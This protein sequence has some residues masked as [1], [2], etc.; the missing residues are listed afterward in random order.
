MTRTTPI[1]A[2]A[3]AGLLLVFA[4]GPATASVD[5][6]EQKFLRG[7][8]ESARVELAKVKGKDRARARALMA[9]ID[10]H[11]GAYEKAEKLAKKLTGKKSAK[12]S[13]AGRLLL[14]EIH[15]LRGRFKDA[16]RELEPM[17]VRDPTNLRARWL[18]ALTYRDLGQKKRAEGLFD[19]FFTDFN[20]GKIDENSGEAIFYVAE[21][22]RYLASYEDA[23]NSYQ[24][25]VQL[26]PKFLEA[27]IQY[28]LFGLEKYAIS[29]A[30]EAFENVLGVDPNHPDAHVGMAQVKLD[31]SYD[32][33]AAYHHLKEALKH[34]PRHV[35]ALL[36]RASLEIDQNKWDAA[37][38]TLGEVF[39]VNADNFR[40]R[41]LLATVHWLR[42][43]TRAY[44]SERKR[45]FA[46]NPG[47][48]EFFHIIARS[49][50]REHR[51]KEAVEL[52]KQ[53]VKVDPEYYAAMGEI[54]SGYLRL[55]MEAEGLDWL[56]K[57]WKGDQYN[58]RTYNV[59]NLFEDELP[60]QYTFVSSKNFKFRY[61]NGEKELLH[62]YVAP[63]L[64]RAFADMVKR[65]GFKPKTPIII[66][67]YS[68][69]Q[70][71][72]VRTVGLPNLGALGVCFGQVITTMS[73]SVG[74]INWAMVGWH[75]L[76]HVFAIQLSNSRV[77]RWFTEGLSEYETLIVRPEWRREHDA[78]VYAALQANQLPS[79]ATLNYEFMKPSMQKIVVAYYLSALT[80]EFIAAHHG[81]AKIVEALKLFGQ[82]KE[83]PEVV[84][85]VT[86]QKVAAFDAA[87]KAYLEK[88][89]A[90]Y[91]GT[92]TL[93][94][95][96]YDDITKLEIAVGA[97]PDSARAHA[98]LALGHFFAGKAADAQAAADKALSLDGKNRIALFVKAELALKN[99]MVDV[100]KATYQALIAAGG[101]SFD[102]RGRLAMIARAGGD[103]DEAIKQLCAAKRLDPERSYPY[104]QLFEIYKARGNTAQALAELETY[105]MLEQMEFGPVKDLVKGYAAQKDWAKVRHYGELAQNISLTDPELFLHLGRAYV[106][107]G[108]PA[109]AL[110]TYDSA[111][112][113]NPRLRRP[114]L[115]H[116]GRARAFLAQGKKRQA[117]KALKKALK[118]EPENAEALELQKQ[119]R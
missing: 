101:D 66:E 78:Q 110:F 98:D 43:N 96:G 75:E 17:T 27:N 31:Q 88:R 37:K 62:R 16:R 35:P 60:K 117:R 36:T 11:T 6:A 84:E 48:A 89:L 14:A 38:K 56:R 59:L 55:G 46:S 20:A 94:T 90:P 41:A 15:R 118:T 12:D 104:M 8:Y 92:F 87:F 100:A 51:Y 70:Q 107:T 47:Y 28:G 54:G 65:Y 63:L 50:V 40:G 95:E 109:R 7:E 77:P 25:A 119:M 106:E 71:Y 57:S 113:I 33:A 102:V 21:A 34:N 26:A 68:D 108:D 2:L 69:P 4:T 1:L 42:D 82:G 85:I 23:N 103:M 93:P 45:V 3:L 32:L 53:A 73:P 10:L 116:I 44:D 112:L 115:A 67:L 30:E 5:S 19:T 97:K 52:E 99:R 86:G 114:A 80:V 61:P 18:L 91:Q 13:A 49:A 76:A 24:E 39:A 58:A 29:I 9:R 79:V 105:V 81:F 64:E 72:G 83:T 111:L 22:A 74:Q